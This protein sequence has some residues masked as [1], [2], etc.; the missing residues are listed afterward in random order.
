MIAAIRRCSVSAPGGS[1]LLGAAVRA[2]A[3]AGVDVED[4]TLR[5]PTLD[6]VFLTLTGTAHP[7][8]KEHAA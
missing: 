4:I 5:R 7:T 3:E 8:T 2:L 1:S 6:E